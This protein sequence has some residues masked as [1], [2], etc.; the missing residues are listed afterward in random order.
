VACAGGL[1]A[2]ARLKE[3]NK[4]SFRDEVLDLVSTKLHELNIL[5]YNDLPGSRFGAALRR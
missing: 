5:G 2:T 3:R 4:G 1:L